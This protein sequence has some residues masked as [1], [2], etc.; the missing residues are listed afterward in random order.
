MT[1]N[2]EKGYDQKL[3]TNEVEDGPSW[4]LPHFQLLE[5]KETTK[6]RI[7]FDSAARCEGVSLNDAM[8]TRPKLQRDILE[9][10]LRFR[11]RPNA[12]VALGCPC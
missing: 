9:L 11:L 7:V 8:L 6:V 10:L 4:Y 3:E 1:A 12:L 5:K 2:V